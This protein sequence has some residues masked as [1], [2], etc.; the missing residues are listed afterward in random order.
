MRLLPLDVTTA[1]GAAINRP[2]SRFANGGHWT[3]AELGRQAQMA[4]DDGNTREALAFLRNAAETELAAASGTAF[5]DVLQLLLRWID[6]TVAERFCP[7]CGAT[8]GQA[9]SIKSARGADMPREWVHEGRL[10]AA[11][12]VVA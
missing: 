8:K 1:L 3:P 6:Q 2:E 7:E 10:N 5:S 12:A 4:L 11:T 9:C